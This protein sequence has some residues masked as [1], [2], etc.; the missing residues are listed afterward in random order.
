MESG[1][2]VRRMNAEPLVC[3]RC[4]K[5]VRD[6]GVVKEATGMTQ[7]QYFYYHPHA[8][9]F[10]FDDRMGVA[11]AADTRW[12]CSVCGCELPGRI[13]EYIDQHSA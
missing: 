8:Q 4:Q 5:D 1:K 12:R 10:M 9:A 3:P 2:V 7:L 13:R 11:T 6:E